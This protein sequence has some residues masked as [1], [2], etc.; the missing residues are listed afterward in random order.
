[1]GIQ[2]QRKAAEATPPCELICR[3]AQTVFR[4]RDACPNGG[5]QP[6]TTESA[7]RRGSPLFIMLRPLGAVVSVVTTR[8]SAWVS[9]ERQLCA[10]AGHQKLQNCCCAAIVHYPVC[11]LS[12]K[13]PGPLL[14]PSRG[15]TLIAL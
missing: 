8:R 15:A 13:T 1:M 9:G 4:T 3:H 14:V 12:R 10:R 5:R 2:S 11:M 6:G 7:Y